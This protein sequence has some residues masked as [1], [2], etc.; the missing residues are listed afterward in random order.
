MKIHAKIATLLG[1]IVI[2]LYGLRESDIKT[3]GILIFY[4]AIIS[5][6]L[7]WIIWKYRGKLN[8]TPKGI[9]ALSV[10]IGLFLWQWLHKVSFAAEI[11]LA[12]TIGFIAVFL[13]FTLDEK[14]FDA[15]PKK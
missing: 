3:I 11:V 13:S 14:F 4:A 2:V 6:P 10:P 7:I 9:V 1:L 5:A 8:K 15:L 12:F